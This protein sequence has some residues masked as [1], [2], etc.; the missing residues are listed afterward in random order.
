MRLHIND[1]HTLCYHM[2]VY[3]L[4][5]WGCRYFTSS[6]YLVVQG[7]MTAMH[8]HPTNILLAGPN[9]NHFLKFF[10]GMV[11]YFQSSNGIV[12][13]HQIVTVL[14]VPHQFFVDAYPVL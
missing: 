7:W 4:I 1:N 11:G 2:Y 6:D 3:R 13:Y 8:I 14:D 10:P 12:H 5:M 9:I